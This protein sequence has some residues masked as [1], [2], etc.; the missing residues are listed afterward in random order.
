MI[1]DFSKSM[2]YL[3]SSIGLW[4]QSIECWSLGV[5]SSKC[6]IGPNRA[7]PVRPCEAQINRTKLEVVGWRYFWEYLLHRSVFCVFSYASVQHS[8][9]QPESFIVISLS[10][11]RIESFISI[12][13]SRN[14]SSSSSWIFQQYVLENIHDIMSDISQ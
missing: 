3:V 5:L 11:L 7:P 13:S 9:S 12:R 10:L 6:L 8:L 14:R 4:P 1:Y 2:E